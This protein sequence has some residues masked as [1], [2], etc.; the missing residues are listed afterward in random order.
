MQILVLEGAH[1]ERRRAVVVGE[2]DLARLR[3]E[4]TVPHTD[5]RFEDKRVKQSLERRTMGGQRHVLQHF[6]V[7]AHAVHVSGAAETSKT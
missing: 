5:L 3:D 7:C 6:G 4:R 1:P 2:N